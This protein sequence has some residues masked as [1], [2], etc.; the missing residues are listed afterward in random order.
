MTPKHPIGPP[1]VPKGPG[2]GRA[3]SPRERHLGRPGAQGIVPPASERP[4]DEGLF[5]SNWQADEAIDPAWLAAYAAASDPAN[6]P[7]SPLPPGVPPPLVPHAAATARADHSFVP[8]PP[9]P[10]PPLPPSQPPGSPPPS[11]LPPLPHATDLCYNCTLVCV[12]PYAELGSLSTT[13]SASLRLEF[14]Y[15]EEA[16]AAEVSPEGER[17]ASEGA[18]PPRYLSPRS[19]HERE[20]LAPLDAPTDEFGGSFALI[21]V[22][23]VSASTEEPSGGR[24]AAHIADGSGLR[25]HVE[26]A[27]YDGTPPAIYLSCP[28]PRLHAAT[29]MLRRYH[30]LRLR[31]H[32]CTP[33]P[34]ALHAPTC[35]PPRSCLHAP[36]RPPPSR[37]TLLLPRLSTLLSATHRT[38][39][40][41]HAHAHMHTPLGRP[42]RGWPLHDSPR[43]TG[44]RGGRRALAARHDGQLLLRRAAW[45]GMR[46]ALLGQRCACV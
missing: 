17:G 25:H 15:G 24:G 10:E 38:A 43:R 5:P 31:W 6:Q 28:C 23:A 19:Q 12:V 32:A 26:G 2:R 7:S 21:R 42:L 1:G 16:V 40:H 37:F 35:T 33:P 11:P 44:R 9:P 39:S 4:Q 3:Y 8:F 14:G 18:S 30:P 45:A 46:R 13:L 29:P 22:T 36:A 41:A 20:V 34:A 27:A